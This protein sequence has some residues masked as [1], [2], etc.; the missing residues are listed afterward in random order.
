MAISGLVITHGAPQV[1]P[2]HGEPAAA[3]TRLDT[4]VAANT[5]HLSAALRA[6]TLPTGASLEIGEAHGPRLPL[7]VETQSRRHDRDVFDAIRSLP[8][9]RQVEVAYVW[10]DDPEL[11]SEP[12][13]S[14]L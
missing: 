6:L 12:Q 4:L 14:T 2:Q 3:P 1:A 10:F 13:E 9:V 7:V 11:G 8:G 5:A